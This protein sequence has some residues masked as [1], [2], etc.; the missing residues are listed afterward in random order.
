MPR[1]VLLLQGRI[2]VGRRQHALAVEVFG[3][4]RLL[5]IDDDLAPGDVD[6]HARRHLHDRDAGALVDRQLEPGGDARRVQVA[7]VAGHGAARVPLAEV[8]VGG[9]EDLSFV[10]AR[11]CDAFAHVSL[12]LLE[13]RLEV[14]VLLLGV[15]QLLPRGRPA[16]C[17]GPDLRNGLGRNRRSG[18]RGRRR[19]RGRAA[20]RRHLDGAWQGGRHDVADGHAVAQAHDVEHLRGGV[21][22]QPRVLGREREL[23]G[24]D[25]REARRVQQLA[26]PH[27]V[28]RGGEGR[29]A[30]DMGA[31]ERLERRLHAGRRRAGLRVA[32]VVRAAQPL[33]QVAE[34]SAGTASSS[35]S[36]PV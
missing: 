16:L 8:E 2:G 9:A 33:Q 29:P 7:L 30:L 12:Q 1:A 11:P 20:H 6:R 34:A 27:Q 3:G 10:E 4:Q 22:E 35:A 19:W 21:R 14:L 13:A 25:G 32:A 31:R 28:H 17:A 5:A 24:Q 15:R 18:R 26:G 23:R 36:P